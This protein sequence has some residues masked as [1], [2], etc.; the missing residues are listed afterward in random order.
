[1]SPEENGRT[2]LA[3]ENPYH[4]PDT[5]P[6]AAV[7]TPDREDKRSNTGC[8]VLFL[9][10]LPLLDS[11]GMV[12]S[13]AGPYSPVVFMIGLGGFACG[14]ALGAYVSVKIKQR[15]WWSSCRWAIY[16]LLGMCL[17]TFI[18]VA[19]LLRWATH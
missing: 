14:A 19:V 8:L 11:F 3:G 17:P 6:P 4:S 12:M 13:L 2:P 1:M 15:R 16:G 7:K 5:S 9:L 18:I 10:A